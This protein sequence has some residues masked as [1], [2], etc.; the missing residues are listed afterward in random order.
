MFSFSWPYLSFLF[1]KE[2]HSTCVRIAL[3]YPPE[4]SGARFWAATV[5]LAIQLTPWT[6]VE[7]SIELLSQEKRG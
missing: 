5:D 6:A 3:Q 7:K 4:G 2:Q 1:G